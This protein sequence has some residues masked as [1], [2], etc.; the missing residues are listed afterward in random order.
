MEVLGINYFITATA[1]ILTNCYTV[2]VKQKFVNNLNI[3]KEAS[4][5]GRRCIKG[6]L[7]ILLDKVVI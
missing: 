4:L 7:V 1:L 5:V 2:L 6:S 3:L